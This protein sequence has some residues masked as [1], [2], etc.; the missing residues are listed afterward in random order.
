MEEFVYGMVG[1]SRLEWIGALT[2]LTAVI[3]T[4]RR[5]VWSYLFGIPCVIIYAELFYQWQLYSQAILYVYYIGMLY[6]GFYW[7]M[8]GRGEDGLVIIERTP[9]AEAAVLLAIVAG[10]IGTLGWVMDTQTDARLPYLDASTTVIAAC[11]QYLQS[12][13]RLMTY[14]AWMVVNV[15]SIALFWYSGNPPTMVLYGVYLLLSIWGT[16]A[17][18]RAWASEGRIATTFA[19]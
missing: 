11:A 7:W 16:V 2:G 9:A 15:L 1:S 19:T 14:P 6:A 17:W 5:S 12:R 4:I 18:Y 3:L 8:N 13:R 10:G